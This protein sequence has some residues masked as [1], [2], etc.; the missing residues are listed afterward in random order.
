[1]NLPSSFDDN[2]FFA[3]LEAELRDPSM[4][5]GQDL[6]VTPDRTVSQTKLKKQPVFDKTDTGDDFFDSLE[7]ELSRDSFDMNTAMKSTADQ[8]DFFVQLEN[9]LTAPKGPRKRAGNNAKATPIVSSESTGL[10]GESLAKNTVPVLKKML[11]ERG[12][13]VSGSK[14]ELI[15][16][17]L[18]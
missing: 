5:T 18:K 3:S 4:S 16:R 10:N 1:M 14:A 17:L 12:L 13:K 15:E 2:D 6:N 8:E 11:K 7:K 9:D